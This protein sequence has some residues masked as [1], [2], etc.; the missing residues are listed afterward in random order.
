MSAAFLHLPDSLKCSLG[1]EGRELHVGQ[2]LACQLAIAVS[3]LW[4]LPSLGS[5]LREHTN[6]LPS[7]P[8]TLPYLRFPLTIPTGV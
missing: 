3:Q 8:R 4:S 5:H 1:E 7:K 6:C 2:A